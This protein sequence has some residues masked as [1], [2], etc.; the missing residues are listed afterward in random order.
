MMA[1]LS[2]DYVGLKLRN[3][4]IVSS[5]G[6]TDSVEKIKNLENAGAG[7]VVLK[8]LFEEQI[9]FEAGHLSQFSDYPEAD[10]YIQNYTRTNHVDQYLDL[11]EQASAAVSIPVMASI[12]C[13]SASEWT[14]FAGKI[15]EAGA[16]ALEL[17]VY[18]LPASKETGSQ[19]FEKLYLDIAEK[20]RRQIRI[21]VIM[22]LGMHFTHPV[23]LVDGL[24]HRGVDGV[25]LFNRFYS[26]DINIR[27]LKMTSS[28]VFSSPTDLRFSLRWV[29]IV[30]AMVDQVHIAGSTG[31]HDGSAMVKLILAGARTVQVCS[32]IYKHGSSVIGTFLQDLN[33][34]MEQQGFAAPDAFRGHMNYSNLPE[35][36]VYERSQFMK[37][38]SSH[39]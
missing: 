32:A 23:S 7:A 19:A 8:S 22:K 9:L 4:L 38:F 6:L 30:S 2:T 34:W 20:V 14:D 26:P 33:G 28:D 24:Y 18:F 11:I 31:V 35:P 36:Q 12:N 25:V 13:V 21:P 29:A 5:S 15:E 10:D 16:A 37:Y 1:D 17:N 39:H 27:D 3:P